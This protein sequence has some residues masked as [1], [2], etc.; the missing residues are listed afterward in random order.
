MLGSHERTT[1]QSS[2]LS[3]FFLNPLL[4]THVRFAWCVSTDGLVKC[5]ERVPASDMVT[6]A[7]P[8]I[9]IRDEQQKMGGGRRCFKRRRPGWTVT[10]ASTVINKTTNWL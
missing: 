5:P 6:P 1:A 8:V 9:P 10:S 4:D 7:P 3:G 2:G